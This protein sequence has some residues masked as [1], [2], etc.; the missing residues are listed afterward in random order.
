LNKLDQ[1]FIRACKSKEPQQ[2]LLSVYRR[3]YFADDK[4][5]QSVLAGILARLC[6]DYLD[7]TVSNLITELHPGNG[8]KYGVDTRAEYYDYW[9]HCTNVLCTQIRLSPITCFEDL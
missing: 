3:F 8:W 6:E 1:L 9:R 4:V 5:A 2:R 7:C